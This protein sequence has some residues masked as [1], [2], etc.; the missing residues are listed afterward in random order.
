MYEFS[1]HIPLF[2]LETNNFDLG[3]GEER[4]GGF[5]KAARGRG[6][7]GEGGIQGIL[8]ERYGGENSM[9]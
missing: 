2:E 1:D 6:K 5:A 8:W 4:N 3:R 9:G 7:T